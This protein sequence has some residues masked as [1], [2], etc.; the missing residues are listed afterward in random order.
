MSGGDL[1]SDTHST[2]VGEVLKHCCPLSS[3]GDTPSRVF[4]PHTSPPLP[5]LFISR[6]ATT[7]LPIVYTC[8]LVSRVDT[9][10]HMC[11]DRS[12]IA[13]PCR[14][15]E[16]YPPASTTSVTHLH[17]QCFRNLERV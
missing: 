5:L 6:D 14:V 9:T 11:S 17:S 10:L 7:N 3:C 16:I 12:I 8:R 1:H 4:H 2:D 15:V 13:V